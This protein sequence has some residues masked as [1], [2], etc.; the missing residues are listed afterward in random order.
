MAKWW[1]TLAQGLP[2]LGTTLAW[3]RENRRKKREETKTIPNP[4]AGGPPIEVT[5]D[6]QDLLNAGQP[7][8]GLGYNRVPFLRTQDLPLA[9]TAADL[10]YLTKGTVG[11]VKP[12][13]D[14]A[15]ENA[16]KAAAAENAGRF[17]FGARTMYIPAG[18]TGFKPIPKLEGL[19]LTEGGQ[20]FGPGPTKEE[21]L[22]TTAPITQRTMTPEEILGQKISTI[23]AQGEQARKTK[24]TP[25]AGAGGPGK[26]PK[27]DA[28][29]AALVYAVDK[30]H[31]EMT[32]VQKAGLLELSGVVK[33]GQGLTALPIARSLTATP[34]AEEGADVRRNKALLWKQKYQTLVGMG[35]PPGMAESQAYKDS[36]ARVE[37]VQAME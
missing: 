32:D 22:G 16:A 21:L 5:A 30:A 7:A 27:L 11:G 13:A 10:E 6:Q 36:G 37:D 17:G 3:G 35:Y 12:P 18:E 14:V 34:K 28:N 8:A 31:P 19:R 15:M 26:T 23:I 24:G 20:V 25:G 4:Y 1:E 33:P 9:K 2:E 29:Q